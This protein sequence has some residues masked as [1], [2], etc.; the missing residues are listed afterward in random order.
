MHASRHNNCILQNSGGL[1]E[2]SIPEDPVPS[3][4]KDSN[5]VEEK[6][7]TALLIETSIRDVMD[8]QLFP[9]DVNLRQKEKLLM[10]VCTYLSASCH[11]PEKRKLTSAVMPQ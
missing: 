5:I 1:E 9:K 8:G 11:L 10:Q 3:P 2:E 7:T 4:K 6:E